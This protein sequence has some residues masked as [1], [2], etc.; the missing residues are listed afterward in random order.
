MLPSVNDPDA[1]TGAA[2]SGNQ[3]PP[4]T[5]RLVAPALSVRFAIVGVRGTELERPN[6]GETR[7]RASF[8]VAPGVVY[9]ATAY[10]LLRNGVRRPGRI[11]L[12]TSSRIVQ[13]SVTG[14]GKLE[15][16]AG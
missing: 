5:T 16:Y 9:R 13:G 15:S 2:F 3:R 14:M 1:A 11:L 12:V 4:L 10:R 6:L 8:A 7:S